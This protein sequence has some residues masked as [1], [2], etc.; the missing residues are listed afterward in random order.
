MSGI[1]ALYSTKDKD[2]IN[3]IS[4]GLYALQHRGQEGVG[5]VTIDDNK[6][7]EVKRR[8]LL[9]EISDKDAIYGVKGNKG[10]AIAKYAFG[11]NTKFEPVMPYVYNHKNG[12]IAVAIDGN[13]ANKDFYISEL[14]EKVNGPEK[15]L[16]EYVKKLEGS[17]TVV[18]ISDEKMVVIRDKYGIKPICIGRIGDDFIASS[19]TAMLDSVGASFVKDLENGEIYIAGKNGQKSIKTVEKDSNLCLFEMI[20]IARPDSSI[21][22]ISVY[23]SRFK[24]GEKLFEESPTKAD[25]VIG[26]PDSGLIAAKGYASASGLPYVDGLIKNR[27]IGRTFIKPTQDERLK[28]V[29]LKLNPIKENIEGKEVILV[30]DSIVRGTTIRRTI[31]ILK[32]AGAKKIHVKIAC[33]QIKYSEKM[34]IDIPDEKDLISYGKTI[35]EVRQEINADSLYFLSLDALEDA[36]GNKGYYEKYFTGKSPIKE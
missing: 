4:V 19:E 31:E 26:A 17:F 5:I 34:S 36:C 7:Y 12:N 8:G 2:A 24:M 35:E 3:I 27:Y 33:P 10:I 15:E 25:I 16:V 22:G 18:L 28:G 6:V 1:C 32:R 14:I 30:D 23:K 11:H 29:H 9:S 20:Y 13:I 21:D